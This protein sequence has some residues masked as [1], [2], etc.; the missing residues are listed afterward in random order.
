MWVGSLCGALHKLPLT[1]VASEPAGIPSTHLAV[2]TSNWWTV[3]CLV[4][5]LEGA[6]VK[7]QVMAGKPLSRKQVNKCSGDHGPMSRAL[8]RAHE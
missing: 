3:E 4:F 1:V 6:E 8:H 2:A 7:V 5:F